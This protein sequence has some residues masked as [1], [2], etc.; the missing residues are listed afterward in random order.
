MFFD[1][2][3]ELEA[4]EKCI[5]HKLFNVLWLTAKVRLVAPN[6]IERFE[7]KAKRVKDLRKAQ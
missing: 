7:G 3:K 1:Q 2:F 4:L 5:T 6:S